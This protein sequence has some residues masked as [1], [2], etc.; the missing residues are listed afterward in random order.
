MLDIGSLRE[1]DAHTLRKRTQRTTC[2]QCGVALYYV[3]IGSLREHD[4]LRSTGQTT[5]CTLGTSRHGQALRAFPQRDVP[6]VHEF[7]T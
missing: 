2:I 7:M 4:A 5:N 3:V 1:T 6:Y